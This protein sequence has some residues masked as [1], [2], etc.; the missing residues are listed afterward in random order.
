VSIWRSVLSAKR[1][2]RGS[3]PRHVS[4]LTAGQRCAF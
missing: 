4:A 3:I 2:K 1:R